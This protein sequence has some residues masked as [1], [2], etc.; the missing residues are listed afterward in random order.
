[1]LTD[2]IELYAFA[3]L[4][5]TMHSPF[6]EWAVQLASIC[7]NLAVGL[8]ALFGIWGIREW[9]RE[10]IGKAKFETARK[11][12]GVAYM[13][14]DAIA[15]ARF[16]VFP[17]YSA[18]RVRQEGETAEQRA[19]LDEEYA[20][21]VKLVPVAKR[22]QELQQESWAAE[23]LFGNKEIRKYIA[24]FMERYREIQYAL[25]SYY[26]KKYSDEGRDTT[27]EWLLINSG[28]NDKFCQSIDSAVDELA[29]Y[30]ARYLH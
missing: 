27:K 1:M 2:S 4:I 18:G 17:G 14:R 6:Q 11:V 25:N 24:P 20:R 23:I 28:E 21:K 13:F 5:N 8:A 7:S 16:P 10:L 15:N 29:D 19:I 12:L 26:F 22:L 30:L 9:R 3:A